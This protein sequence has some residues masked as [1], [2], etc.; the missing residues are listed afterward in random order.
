MKKVLRKTLIL[1]FW[2]AL[3]LGLALAVDNSI[4]VATPL[5]TAE[6]CLELLGTADFYRAV[7]GSLL[8]IGAGFLAGSC[9]AVLLAAAAG[10]SPLLE[11]LFAPAVGFLKAAPVASF[12]VVLL[13]WWGS[14]FLGVAVS[15]LVVLPNVYVNT[16]EGLKSVDGELLEMA[17]L[18][19]LP[20]SSRLFYLYLPALK[21]FLYGSLK[22]SLGMCWKS[23]VAAEVIGTPA[24]SIGG[25]LY[26]S[27]VYLDTAGVFAWT[28]AV[29]L[30]SAL[31]EKLVLWLTERLFVL[32][33]A[34]RCPAGAGSGK[35]SGLTAEGV[36]KRFGGQQVL[37]DVNLA[38]RPGEIRCLRTPS[39][40]GKTTLLRILAGL[41][42]PDA[43]QV[44]A[45]AGVSMVFQEDRLC[46]EFSAVKNVALATGEEERAR[47]A[48]RQ[49]LEEEALDKPC[50][51]L[52]GGM[53]RR[54]ALVRA[55][56]ADS[57]AVLLD[58]PF[59]GMDADT[60][61]RAEAYVRERQ[62]GRAI[63]IATHV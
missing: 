54:V 63:V 49:V 11:E 23:G 62:N 37:K 7:A 57:A 43:G 12:V 41:T 22:V 2:L 59:A 4:L 17:R 61:A 53:K 34:C 21:P 56:E 9:A 38:C 20:G 51:T 46:P 33:P 27:K 1:L 58:E 42:H 10:R 16:L 48:L 45:P 32:Q 36:C 35:E 39:G 25:E 50:G 30:L 13:I 19:R 8:R 5:Q 47:E 18:F 26:L 44:R 6:R 40:S 52:S 3:W 24:C 60:R 28:A 31:F 14:S 15:F 29:I 55:M